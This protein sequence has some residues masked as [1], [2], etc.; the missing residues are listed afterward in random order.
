MCEEEVQGLLMLSWSDG[1][2]K[3]SFGDGGGFL[4][5]DDWCC[6]RAGLRKKS[7]GV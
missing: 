4:N 2:E 7:R 1:D 6:L 3:T 5:G